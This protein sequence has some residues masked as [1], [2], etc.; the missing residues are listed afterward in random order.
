M[1]KILNPLF[2]AALC[3]SFLFLSGCSAFRAQV[4]L[5]TGFG[6]IAHIPGVVKIGACGGSFMHVGHDYDR[7]WTAGTGDSRFSWDTTLN[8]LGAWHSEGQTAG[9]VFTMSEGDKLEVRNRF[10]CSYLPPLT[11][12]PKGTKHPWAFEIHAM[13]LFVDLR[14]GFNPAYL[15]ADTKSESP[16]PES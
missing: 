12:K 15:G 6:A 7:G 16:P 9:S 4:G 8:V 5:G 3:G 11:G 2:V 1:M 13:L 10:D 14:L